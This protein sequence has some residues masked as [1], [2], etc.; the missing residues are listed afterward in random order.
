MGVKV[1]EKVK[2]SGE[3]W[4]F[5]HQNGKRK[6]K[7]IGKDKKI[8]LRVAREIEARLTLRKYDMED[9]PDNVPLLSD[10]GQVWLE[11]YIRG[12]R[13]DNTYI[14][15][16]GIFRKYIIPAEIGKVPLNRIKRAD[17]KRFLMRLFNDGLSR[18]S[19][20]VINIV[21][22]GIMAHAT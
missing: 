17:I 7:L 1:R 6:T 12:I 10:Y 14:R 11:T 5:I 8:A 20:G 15:Y 22:S 21:L 4:I 9:T 2:G 13:R 18:S 19:V 3:W 16:E